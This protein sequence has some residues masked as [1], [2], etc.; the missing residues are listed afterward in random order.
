MQVLWSFFSIA[1]DNSMVANSSRLKNNGSSDNA[2]QYALD[3]TLSVEKYCKS[4]PM[5]S[6]WGN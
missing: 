6:K 2:V 3:D 4:F 5:G 1:D